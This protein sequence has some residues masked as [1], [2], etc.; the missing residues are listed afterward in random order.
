MNSSCGTGVIYDTQEC[1]QQ[2]DFEWIVGGDKFLNKVHSIIIKVTKFLHFRLVVPRHDISSDSYRAKV[3]RFRAGTA[4]AEQ[5]N[6]LSLIGLYRV[7]TIAPPSPPAPVSTVTIKR[8]L[9]S[10]GFGEVF[11]VWNVSTGAQYALK[12]PKNEDRAKWIEQEIVIM[13]RIDH[14]SSPQII[15]LIML[16]I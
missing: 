5:L 15:L 2:S 10:G 16:T 7:K 13:D 8:P 9:G 1:G 14:V 6:D 11:H 12:Q 4:D 3:D